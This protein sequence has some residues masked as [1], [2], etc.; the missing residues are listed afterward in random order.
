MDTHPYV[1]NKKSRPWLQ[2][3]MRLSWVAARSFTLEREQKDRRRK[4][5]L[6]DTVAKSQQT[7]TR[8]WP[9]AALF[10]HLLEGALFFSLYG[11]HMLSQS[12]DNPLV[13]ATC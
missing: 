1:S 7:L 6:R 5:A 11:N 8:V 4:E 2:Y 9:F 13:M 12:K 3:F 10:S